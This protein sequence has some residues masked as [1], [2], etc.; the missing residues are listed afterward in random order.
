LLMLHYPS[1]DLVRKRPI[2]PY[3]GSCEERSSIIEAPPQHP[4][5]THKEN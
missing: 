5:G 1:A 3:Q 2:R 4:A